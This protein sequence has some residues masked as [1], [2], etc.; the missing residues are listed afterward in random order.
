MKSDYI[1]DK[2][3]KDTLLFLLKNVSKELTKHDIQFWVD[4]G[5]LLG[6][7][8][9]KGIIPWD[10]DVDISISELDSKRLWDLRDIFTKYNY[11]I[12]KTFFGYKIFPITGKKI[13][14]DTWKEH[15]QKFKEENPEIKG[16]CNICIEASK[17]YIR[18]TNSVYRDYLYPSLD[19][20]LT[21]VE[22]SQVIYINNLWE[23][24]WISFSNL[25]PL[26]E[27]EGKVVR[28]ITRRT[29]FTK[30]VSQN[31]LMYL[32][33]TIKEGER[34]EDIAEFYY[35]STDFT[36]VVYFSNHII[37]PYHDWPKSEADFNNYLIDKYGELSGL[38]GEDIVDWARDD[39]P[40]NILYYLKRYN[41]WQ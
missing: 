41:Q 16:R 6:A 7:V 40:E 32:P 28:D 26:I 17:S 1:L 9:H 15:R 25:F 12:V 3:T 39:N 35:G 13:K 11:N 5:T 34:P 4:G 24:S 14:I 22:Y 8:R 30:E 21:K 27:Y 36:W 19:I 2:E 31:P 33:Y 20:F 29:S 18:P 10:D 23:H 37:D 38:I